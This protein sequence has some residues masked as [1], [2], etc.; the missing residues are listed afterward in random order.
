MAGTRRTILGIAAA[1]MFARAVGLAG[2][3]P[4]KPMVL[5]PED[6]QWGPIAGAPADVKGMDLW[7]NPAKGPHGAVQKFQPGFSAP[8][9]THSN[10]LHVFVISGT[11]ITSPE[12]GPEKKLPAGSYIFLPS[13]YKHITKCDTGSEC[14]V[15]IETTGKFDV[16][17]VEEKKPA[18]MK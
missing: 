7:G 15:L 4:R 16:K 11:M 1:V 14:V 9:H 17:P 2:A 5:V 6:I 12:G 8:L 13:T 3:E 18:G 10:D